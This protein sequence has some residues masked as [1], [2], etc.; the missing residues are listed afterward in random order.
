[1]TKLIRVSRLCLLVWLAFLST[2]PP[3]AAL[4]QTAAPAPLLP[5]AQEA[6]NKGIIA[7]K[8]PD[9][10]LAIRFFEDARKL[11]P[12]APVIFMNLGI[13]ESKMPGRELRTIAWFGAYLA[14]SP[15]APNAAAVKEQIAV[16]EVKNQSNVSRLIKTVQDAAIQLSG[17]KKRDGL[18]AVGELWTKTGDIAAA[19]KT[20]D[21]NEDQDRSYARY[22][23]SKA[24][25]EDGDIAGA[26]KT[27]E[28]VRDAV[29][30]VDARSAIAEAQQKS[31]DIAGVQK[32]LASAQKSADLIK[33]KGLKDRAQQTIAKVQASSGDIAGAQK[34]ANLIR[35]A[36]DKSRTLLAIAINQIESGDIAGAQSTLAAVLKTSEL[37]EVVRANESK[38][39]SS[40]SEV[41][42][43]IAYAQLRTGDI[44]GAQR[45]VD[46]IQDAYYKNGVQ[47]SVATA[48][49]EHRVADAPRS[50]SDPQP[51]IRPAIT[52]SGWLAELGTDDRGNIYSSN[53]NDPVFLD[54]AG[55]LKSLNSSLKSKVARENL[56]MEIFRRKEA[57]IIFDDLDATARQMAKAQNSI[58]QLLK[59][60]AIR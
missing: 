9:Y 32:T 45:T 35:N 1:M 44:A 3:S 12:A 8:V 13:A 20:A 60:Q 38:L 30:V 40:K 31:G 43:D 41:Q 51:P 54:L 6:L 58:H 56:Q 27:A 29:H 37:I 21:L 4:A 39:G 19:V 34:T 17:Y 36:L 14:A 24:Q 42:Q 22:A 55:H 48:R 59:Q 28:L 33:E 5:A 49:T 15:D 53:L 50:T 11:A 18:W 10:P 26:Q 23:I 25:A 57:E 52:V 46:L 47:G 2:V 7:A 16:L